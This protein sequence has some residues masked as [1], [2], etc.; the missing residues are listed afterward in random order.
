MRPLKIALNNFGPFETAEIDFD[1]FNEANLF[2]I[3]GD[4]GA[5]K[6]T[7]FDAMTYALF[8]DKEIDRN[9]K[10]MRSE[11]ADGHCL[12]EVKFWFEHNGKYYK[13]SRTPEQDILK[14]NPKDE[15]DTT[16]KGSTAQFAEVDHDLQQETSALGSKLNEVNEAIV[17]ML[18]L[19][20]RQFRQIIILP[21]NQFRKFLESAS[22]DKEDILRTLFGTEI[23]QSFSDRL[24][25]QQKLQGSSIES[26]QVE[27]KTIFKGIDWDDKTYDNEAPVSDQFKLLQ[28]K[29]DQDTKI[30]QDVHQK[31]AVS[32]RERNT[33]LEKQRQAEQLT[34]K[35]QLLQQEKLKSAELVGQEVQINQLRKDLQRVQWLNQQSKPVD[36][37]KRLDKEKVELEISQTKQVDENTKLTELEAQV[38]KQKAAIKSSEDKYQQSTTQEQ[39]ITAEL[40]PAAKQLVEYQSTKLTSSK[41]LDELTKSG[42]TKQLSS[43]QA[44]K[45][46]EELQSKL[47]SIPETNAARLQL[48]QS[49]EV[50]KEVKL[51]AD[52]LEVKLTRQTELEKQ[53]SEQTVKH[54]EL[55]AQLKQSSSAFEQGKSKRQELMIALLQSELVEGEPCIVCNAIYDGNNQARQHVDQA[56]IR[57]QINAVEELEQQKNVDTKNLAV[58]VNQL[59]QT[60]NELKQVKTEV[61]LLNEQLTKSYLEFKEAWKSQYNTELSNEYD[62]SKITAVFD[63]Q[64][65][66]IDTND[67]QRESISIEITTLNGQIEKILQAIAENKTQI[68]VQE[69]LISTSQKSIDVINQQY[70]KLGSVAELNSELA[71]LQLFTTDFERQ[72]TKLQ[73]DES[74]FK[75]R[76]ASWKTNETTIQKQLTSY[77]QQRLASDVAIKSILQQ[78]ELASFE[79]LQTEVMAV[80]GNQLTNLMTE[81][82]EYDTKVTENQHQLLSLGDELKGEVQP[83]LAEIKLDVQA[84]DE[85]FKLVNEQFTMLKV[86]LES[87]ESLASRAQKLA[88]QIEQAQANGKA[89]NDLVSAVKGNNQVKLGLERFVLRNFL[90]EVLQFAN[91]HYIGQLS[92]GRYQFKLSDESSGRSNQNGLNIDVFDGETST[93]RSSSTLSGGESFIAALSIALSLAEIV[94]EHAGGVRIEALFIDEGFGTLDTQTLNQAMEAL[95]SLESTGRLVGIISHVE[96]MKREISQQ[97]LINKQGD[98]RSVVKYREL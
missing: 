71:E 12:T 11:F 23:Y 97:I 68:T 46:Q 83:N 35:F 80:G 38:A 40:L 77:E 89:I 84:K 65:Q 24:A 57:D 58:L 74:E 28:T 60:N 5:G 9:A 96:S 53:Q 82:T 13:V 48:S 25:A 49:Q 55:K 75:I 61:D 3:S 70:S 15:N 93:F 44:Q 21:Q 8:G 63:E 87:L 34:N 64:S 10:E 19:N 92:A 67:Q 45:Q 20:A 36:E 32:E 88:D 90:N 85:T 22:V 4:T 17:E 95:S 37:V 79:E 31:L 2:L 81:I 29:I 42:H 56:D 52:N 73:Q 41:L 30:N 50:A 26:D 91:E 69:N 1:H 33:S 76:Q 78:G 54:A 59:E 47:S 66:I 39:L 18:H 72:S 86:K 43:E 27:L 98:G 14:K 7:I 94:Q 16:K 51:V 6:T 62:Q